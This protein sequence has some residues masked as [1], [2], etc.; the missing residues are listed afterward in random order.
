MKNRI[1]RF[2]IQTDSW[3]NITEEVDFYSVEESGP[4]NFRKGL[5][6]MNSTFELSD[7][8]PN[9]SYEIEMELVYFY[10]IEPYVIRI[11]GRTL[12]GLL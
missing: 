9:T 7:L 6:N 4:T 5:Y 10:D 12:P 8:L 11:Y 2:L 3:E 1:C